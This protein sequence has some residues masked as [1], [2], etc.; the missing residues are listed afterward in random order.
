MGV[1]CRTIGAFTDLT[2]TAQIWLIFGKK[3]IIINSIQDGCEKTVMQRNEDV[4]LIAIMN[5][6]M[7][8]DIC[9]QN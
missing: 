3:I 5:F 9:N 1:G 6:H 2:D 8:I 4:K 7:S